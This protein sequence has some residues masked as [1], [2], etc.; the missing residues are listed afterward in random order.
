LTD[1]LINPELAGSSPLSAG[2]WCVVVV[3]EKVIKAVE[4]K[5]GCLDAGIQWKERKG[6]KLCRYIL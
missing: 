6:E 2:V 1:W 5:E 4:K 3:V